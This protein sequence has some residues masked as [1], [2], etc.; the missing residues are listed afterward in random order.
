[1][2]RFSMPRLAPMLSLAAMAAAVAW[3]ALGAIADAQVPSSAGS[4]GAL[5][6]NVALE[7][8]DGA[9]RE[10]ET[11][12]LIVELSGSVE[13]RTTWRIDSLEIVSSGC[14]VE[15]DVCAD[16]DVQGT[17]DL[18]SKTDA[19]ADFDRDSSWVAAAAAE[20]GA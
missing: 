16:E 17:S 3:L 8:H 13:P 20:L 12:G 4:T 10:G 1:M 14:R 7:G 2:P 15:A 18:S 11:V 6:L 9:L 5:E 19:T